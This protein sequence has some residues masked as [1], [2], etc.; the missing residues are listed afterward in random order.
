MSSYEKQMQWRKA[1]EL[2]ASK[3]RDDKQIRESKANTFAPTK[4]SDHPVAEFTGR[5]REINDQSAQQHVERQRKALKEKKARQS[6]VA[7]DKSYGDG[8]DFIGHTLHSSPHSLTSQREGGEGRVGG[9]E[10]SSYYAEHEEA[11]RARSHSDQ[12]HTISAA[13]SSDYYKSNHPT[14]GSNRLHKGKHKNNESHYRPQDLLSSEDDSD[15]DDDDDDDDSSGDEPLV[16]LLER[17][18]KQWREERERLV[19][20]I[21][22]QQ[23]ELT[24]RSVAAH[25]RA[26]DIAKEFAR[27]IEC[28]EDRLV[29]VESTVQKEILSVKGIAESLLTQMQIL[30][31][32][33]GL[34]PAANN[35]NNMM[36]M[37]QQT[38]IQ[39]H[40]QHQQQQQ[41]QQSGSAMMA[42]T[43]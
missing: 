30:N 11:Y 18:R 41:Q 13:S 27:A 32:N 17:E 29:S 36:N 4:Y 1:K 23:L 42:R 3:V 39:Q 28:F 25:E 12:Q 5:A 19:Q 24:Q 2:K 22:L 37:Q 26:V 9:Y 8:D 33:S 43:T 16:E 34:T 14:H 40:Q 10:E 6:K 20:C 21:H 35:A 7:Q 31:S 15:D 38:P